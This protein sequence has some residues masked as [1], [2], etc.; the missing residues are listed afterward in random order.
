[1]EAYLFV[2]FKEKKTPDGEQV[3]FAL[4][5][6]GFHWERAN[7]GNPVLESRL[8]EQGVRDHTIVRAKNGKFYIIATD[9]S[10]ANSFRA[11]YKGN[12]GNVSTG[13]SKSLSLW[14]SDD[15]VNWLEQRL[16]RLGDEQFGC[17]WAPDVIYDPERDDY[18]LHWSS[19]HVSNGHGPKA[20]YYSRTRDFESFSPPRLLC[21]KADS[22]II[23]SA[24]YEENGYFYR[25]LKSEANPAAIIL[26]KGSSLT[27]DDYVRIEA[28]DKEMAKLQQGVYEAPTAF[29]LSNGKW[30]LMLDFYGVEGEGQGYV[31]FVAE[32]LDSGQFI[33]SDESFSFPYGF[34]HGTVLSITKDEYERIKTYF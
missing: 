3:Y 9:L 29:K 23:D 16:I 18:V 28:F 17:L 32:T 21:R 27:G 4:S 34:K 8:G 19:S 13:G 6:D 2:H 5:L 12:W 20:I 26:E 24:I 14:E 15:L 31:P 30:C 10:L 1:M 7:G 33:R 22:G 25:F 11:K